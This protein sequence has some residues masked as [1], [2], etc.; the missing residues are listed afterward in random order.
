VITTLKGLIL[1]GK[2]D[3]ALN[4]IILDTLGSDCLPLTQKSMYFV[5]WTK[6]VNF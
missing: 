3:R 2:I 4:Y 6:N 5:M 1:N